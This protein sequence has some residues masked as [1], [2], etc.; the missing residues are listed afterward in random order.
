[1]SFSLFGLIFIFAFGTTT[2]FLSLSLH[3]IVCFLQ[4]RFN[5]NPYPCLEWSTNGTLQQQRL[6]H[7]ELGLG[8]WDGVAKTIP[9]TRTMVDLASLDLSD[10]KHPR[11]KDPRIQDTTSDENS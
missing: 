8:D 11:L 10:R 7:E 6:A 5:F 1:M 4:G 9:F 2:I 3:S